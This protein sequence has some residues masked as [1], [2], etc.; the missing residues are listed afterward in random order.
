MRV[1]RYIVDTMPDAMQK[2]R[3]ELGADAVILS[4][5][6]MKIGGFMGMFRKKKIEVVAAT[7]GS[8]TGASK[9]ESAAPQLPQL[10][11]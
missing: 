2:I 11:Q 1:K 8:D 5:K 3:D 6:E 7:E 4:T 10:D 9:K